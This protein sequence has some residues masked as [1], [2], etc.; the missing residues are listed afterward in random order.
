[1]DTI[2]LDVG[3]TTP[4]DAAHAQ[5][6][7]CRFVSSRGL[8][9]SCDLH[10]STPRSSYETV[11][12]EIADRLSDHTGSLHLSTDMLT[13]FVD[14]HLSRLS[15]PFTLVTGDSDAEVGP[16]GL[17]LDRVQRLLDHP[18]L[19]DWFSQNL[20]F[21]HQKLHHLPI[22]LDYHTISS[23]GEID[24]STQPWASTQTLR[25]R[26]FGRSRSWG[27]RIPPL[28]QERR[29]SGIARRSTPF[30]RRPAKAYANWFR[31][32]G[33]GDREECFQQVDGAAAF[34][35]RH[36]HPRVR[37]WRRNARFAF[38]LSP[39][40]VGYDCHRTW[41]AL[42]LGSVPIVHTS[43]L[44]GLFRDLPVLVID[45][46]RDVTPARLSREH[47]R[48]AAGRFDFSRLT[49]KHWRARINREPPPP[50]M[51]MTLDQFTASL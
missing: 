29:L 50:P 40:G 48:F 35:E 13:D 1:M 18:L 28:E 32:R 17:S 14:N 38:T 6:A 33:R 25:R 4:F 43:P 45:D 16:R 23:L 5:E 31:S 11:P 7:A 19:I 8:L 2:Q 9:R 44:D 15:R 24:D 21:S 36:F 3:T 41:E 37:S 26:L 27:A 49:L 42:A 34:Y 46:W 39:F 12:A 22:G 20:A 10:W 30:S 51:F 47:E